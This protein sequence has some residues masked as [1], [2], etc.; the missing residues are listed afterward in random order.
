MSDS[1]I[2]NAWKQQLFDTSPADRKAAEGAVR[3]F[4]AA[5]GLSAPRIAWF[6]SPIEAAWAVAALSETTSWLGKHI[7]GTAQAAE[8]AKAEKARAELCAALGMDWNS[9]VA[10]AG[11]PLGSSFMCMSA[12][13]IQQQIVSA[14][15]DLGGGDV[16]A[17]F[18]VFDDKDELFRAEKHLRRNGASC[19]RS[20]LITRS[21]PCFRRISTRTIPFQQWPRTKAA[22]KDRRRPF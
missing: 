12:A 18:R 19:A 3:D 13:N 1:P 16:S 7:L 10:A 22:R 5:A 20:R 17:L 11:A 4:Y 6:E 8:K 2:R 14:R 15:M 21:G 9:V